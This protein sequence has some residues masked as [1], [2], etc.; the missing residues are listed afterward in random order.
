[1]QASRRMH[2]ECLPRELASLCKTHS[3]AAGQGQ[4]QGPDHCWASVNLQLYNI[5]S[6]G[7]SDF[8]PEE[9]LKTEFNLIASY[10]GHYVNK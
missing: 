10:N 6:C 8:S 9:Q 2:H 4:Q 3:G 5:L 7:T 1:M